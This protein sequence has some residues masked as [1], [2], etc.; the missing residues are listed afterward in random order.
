[1]IVVAVFLLNIFHPGQYLFSRTK[2]RWADSEEE[3]KSRAESE[4]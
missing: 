1:M 4:P 3:Q 2:A